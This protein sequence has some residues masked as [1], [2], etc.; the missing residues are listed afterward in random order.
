MKPRFRFLA[1][2]VLVVI[3]FT[4]SSCAMLQPL[5]E[6]PDA[7]YL[8][9]RT[10]FNNMMKDYL[11]YKEMLPVDQQG[12]MSAIFKPYFQKADLVLDQWSAMLSAGDDGVAQEQIW[13]ERKRLLMQ[14][15]I[16]HGIVEVK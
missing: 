15:L 14:L 5:P 11:F 4:M 6:T 9:A 3:S 12:E 7:K 13:L 8:L 16:E 2:F 1:V 10:E